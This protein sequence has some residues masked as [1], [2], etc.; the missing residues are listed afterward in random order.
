[1][2]KSRWLSQSHNP[3]ISS[4]LCF[5]A[6][7]LML[8]L[9]SMCGRLAFYWGHW[10][11]FTVNLRHLKIRVK[12]EKRIKNVSISHWNEVDLEYIVLTSGSKSYWKDGLST[13][14]VG[15]GINLIFKHFGI[16]FNKSGE[17]LHFTTQHINYEVKKSIRL[18]KI[19]Y[20]IA[21]SSKTQ[22]LWKW[23]IPFQS[24]RPGGVRL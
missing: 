12:I 24:F 14:C 22:H 5:G 4:V 10:M 18:L 7:G 6:H 13:A 2:H 23:A 16:F 11:I 19:A 21:Q 15:N 20:V 17:T 3:R 1:M 9:G 8:I